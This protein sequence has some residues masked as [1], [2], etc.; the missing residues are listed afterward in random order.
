VRR[1]RTS[2]VLALL[3]PT[4]S[5]ILGR[6]Q[7]TA[8]RIKKHGKF[9]M[10]VGAFL[11]LHFRYLPPLEQND[12]PESSTENPLY[13]SARLMVRRGRNTDAAELI[14]QPLAI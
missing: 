13:V 2:E 10:P 5:S 7:E 14:S 3:G 11:S 9:I 4:V 12:R 6:V 1:I 8:E